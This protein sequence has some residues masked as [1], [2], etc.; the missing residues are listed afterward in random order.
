M[1][2]L[3]NSDNS[4]TYRWSMYNAFSIESGGEYPND[5]THMNDVEMIQDANLINDTIFML[6][7]R[8][9]DQVIFVSRNEG[10][11][12]NLTIGEDD[13]Y[14]V[15]YEQHNPDYIHSERGGP[16]V[17]IA[18][19]QNNRII[20]YQMENNNWSKSWE[21]SD[22]KMRWPRDA[23]RLP[24]GNTLIAD[25]NSDRVL[26]INQ[27]GEIIW[28]AS[29]TLNYDVE[30][31]GTGDESATGESAEY[32]NLSSSTKTRSQVTTSS[33]IV[34]VKQLVD[35]GSANLLSLLPSKVENA[36]RFSAPGWMGSA[37]MLASI[38]FLSDIL[39]LILISAYYSSYTLRI[40]VTRN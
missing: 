8:N 38:I 13:N 30:R 33:P 3:D 25:S 9:H 14:Q 10:L 5:W 18:D 12:T 28:Q 16:A 11:Y 24:N 36:I 21:Y 2:I 17:I 20:E 34:T 32:L 27:S 22:S 37:G 31:L 26:E 39:L 7:P 1:F 35:R 4:I 6:S 15:M 19:S 40:T 29:V 23:D